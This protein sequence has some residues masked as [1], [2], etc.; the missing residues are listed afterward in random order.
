[1]RRHEFGYNSSV[2]YVLKCLALRQRYSW[3]SSLVQH[4]IIFWLAMNQASVP[5]CIIYFAPWV[6]ISS[7]FLLSVEITIVAYRIIGFSM[8]RCHSSIPWNSLTAIFIRLCSFQ[9]KGV[10]FL[11]SVWAQI[12]SLVFQISN[13]SDK[14]ENGW[15]IV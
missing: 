9:F 2:L 11:E 14:V 1:M 15:D 5:I 3:I 10:I 7:I 8:V 13:G 4:S 12:I 6:W